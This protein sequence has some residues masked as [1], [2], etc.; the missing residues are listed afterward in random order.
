MKENNKLKKFIENTKQRYQKYQKQQQQEYFNKETE[1]FRQ[2]RL[3]KYKKVYEEA[4]DSE[5]KAEEIQ[6]GPDEE[7]E[8]VE[9][10]KKET[11]QSRQKRKNIFEYLNKDVKRNNR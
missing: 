6:Y 4:S 7:K 2:K 11:K 10:G 8:Y 3:T 5:P 9:E 1:Y